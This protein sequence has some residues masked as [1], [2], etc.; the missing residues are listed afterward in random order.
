MKKPLLL[1]ICLIMPIFMFAKSEPADNLDYEPSE[2]PSESAYLI[3]LFNYKVKSANS[4]RVSFYS[5]DKCKFKIYGN[6]PKSN[7]WEYLALATLKGFSDKDTQTF[8][9][10]DAKNWRYFAIDSSEEKD[11]I[12]QVSVSVKT[13]FIEVRDAGDDFNDKPLPKFTASDNAVVFDIEKLD[14]ED[15]LVIHNLTKKTKIKCTPYYFDKKQCNWERGHEIATV[16]GYDD[17]DKIE[18][19]DDGDMDNLKYIAVEVT[20]WDNDYSFKLYEKRGDLWLD[21]DD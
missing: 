7:E 21:I 6:N 4:A 20:P 3:D 13:I 9:N 8:K 19:L 16:G 1:L 10:K 11:F 15:Y 2:L 12:Y 5:N 14:A 17:T 18:V